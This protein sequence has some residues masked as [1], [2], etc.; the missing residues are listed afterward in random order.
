MTLVRLLWAFGLR[1]WL[2]GCG[3]ALMVI[4]V[5]YW[6][7]ARRERRGEPFVIEQLGAFCALLVAA[8]WLAAYPH[9][10]DGVDVPLRR[11]AERQAWIARFDPLIPTPPTQ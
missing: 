9:D 11:L 2:A 1:A 3:V 7:D 10:D 6:L 8:Y 4:S 5:L